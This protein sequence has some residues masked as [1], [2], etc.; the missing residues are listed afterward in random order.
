MF[1][2]PR[3][4]L[5]RRDL[6]A[7][8]MA[9]GGVM[10]LPKLAFG[11][12]TKRSAT[13]KTLVLLHLNGGN[14]GLNTVVPYKNPRYRTLRP[15]VGLD[16]GQVRKISE[17][18][19]FHPG[20]QGF[21]ALFKRDRLA[22]V[23]GVGYPQ[24]N[25][26]HFR[27]TEIWFTAQPEKTP[28]Y[29]WLGRAMTAKASD[30]P[31]RGVAIQKEAPLSFASETPSTVTMTD[32][33]RFRL[34]SG[35]E[36]ASKLYG[37]YKEL[38]GARA[39]LGQAGAQAI[40]VAKRIARLKNA[41]GPFYGGIGTDL[42][43]VLSLLRA[44]LG[45]ECIQFQM[46]GYDTHSNQAASHN[47][48]MTQ[49]GNNLNAFQTELEKSGLG[50]RVVTVVMSE[51]GRRASENISGGTDHGSAGPVFV[52]GKGVNAGFHGAY[53]S[54]DDLDRDNLKFTTDFRR[55]Y[56]SL[57]ASTFQMD[58]TPILGDFKP[59]ELFA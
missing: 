38:G 46:G 43:K 31:L 23:N 18:L 39:E 22:V 59:L 11:D 29:G 37:Q 14:D 33:A 21:E 24:P 8:A 53:P 42:R 2:D 52:M 1:T 40:D 4:G 58:P 41:G 45:L 12:D 25:Y 57:I 34:P 5:S 55:I 26:S 32:F 27:S 10:A 19:G 28:T 54:L 16:R 49:L 6:L 3:Q 15:S 48:L 47:R 35:M 36:S 51:F 30:A 9:L 20:L 7:G 50:D 13:G 56:A 44:D 17:N